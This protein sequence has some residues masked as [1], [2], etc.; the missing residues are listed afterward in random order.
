MTVNQL[1]SG[2]GIDPQTYRYLAL[3]IAQA[4]ELG[5]TLKRS[6]AVISSFF[7]VW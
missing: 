2:L 7:T 6:P 3:A 5:E 1:C 4:H